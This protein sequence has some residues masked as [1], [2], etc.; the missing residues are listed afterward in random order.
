MFAL[1]NKSPAP[2]LNILFS[3]Y[4]QFLQL[5]SQTQIL[6]QKMNIATCS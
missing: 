1:Y 2:Q 6:S 3:K 4:F 5:F